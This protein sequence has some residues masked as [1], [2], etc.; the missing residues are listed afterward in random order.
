MTELSVVEAVARARS[1]M[2]L[3]DDVPARGWRVERLDRP[4][5][6]Y[7]LTV[8]GPESASTAVV[9]IS[10]FTGE[11]LSSAR[12]GGTGP[13][14]AIDKERAL[15]LAD[16]TGS[17]EGRLVWQPCGATRSPMYPLWEISFSNRTVYVDQGGQVHDRLEPA[18]PGG[19]FE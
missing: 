1:E 8:F 2:G 13:H 16:A 15:A 14:P 18:G 4:E 7:F 5:E 10:V 12:L 3:S 19:G 11:L 17:A 6:A 9:A